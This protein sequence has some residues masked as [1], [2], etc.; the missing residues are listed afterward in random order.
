MIKVGLI[1][2]GCSKNQ[3][4][5]ELIL[6]TV[7]SE[8]SL[9]VVDDLNIADIIIINTC[10]FIQAAKEESIETILEAARLKE[11][12]ELKGII[13]TGCLTQRYKDEIL[14]EIPE[15]DAILGTGTFG[16]INQVINDVLNGKRVSN[17]GNPSYSYKASLPRIITDSHFAYVKIAEGCNNNCTYCS[18]PKIRGPFYSRQ[19][20]DIEEEVRHLTDQ[21]IK[22]I[23]LV[24]QDITRYGEDIYNRAVLPELLKR[25]IKNKDIAWLRLMYS[26][27]E[28][29]SE[30]LI[31]LIARE[32]R[33]CNYLDLPIQHS[34]DR[35][36]RLMNRRASR[37]ELTGLVSK[38]RE[39]IPDIVIRTS[40][41]VGFPGEGDEEF[42]DLLRFIEEVE[43]DRLGVFKYSQEE[44]TAAAKFSNQISDDLK[45]ARYNRIMEIQQKISYNNNQKMI[46]RHLDVIIDEINDNTAIGR[47]QYD[48]PEIDNQ[49]YIPADNIEIGDMVNCKIREAYEYDLIGELNNEA[50]KDEFTK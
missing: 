37:E 42:Q 13:V 48:A 9:E 34:S 14:K 22:E 18:I 2:L 5:S 38:L 16:D 1:S 27:P 33:I 4:D 15:V 46:N 28:N 7:S 29:V 30:E 10:G 40:I 32:D 31:E 21:G 11:T 35:I 23:I 44:G 24:A 25:L 6:G 39:R 8:N 36:R 43:F 19:I 47:T 17:I 26:Y 41:I 50:T 49:I 3:V 12:A 20:E 45:D